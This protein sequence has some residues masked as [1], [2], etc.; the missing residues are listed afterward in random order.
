MKSIDNIIKDMAWLYLSEL[1]DE[2]CG[3]DSAVAEHLGITVEELEIVV[4]NLYY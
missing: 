3:N 1:I 2:C 4:N